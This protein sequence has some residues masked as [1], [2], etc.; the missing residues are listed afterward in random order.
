M[1]YLAYLYRK[2]WDTKQYT[3]ACGYHRHV[4]NRDPPSAG[5]P[6]LT[7]LTVSPLLQYTYTL[8]KHLAATP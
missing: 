1:C 3:F 4:R 5:A 8:A 2:R 6:A 7:L